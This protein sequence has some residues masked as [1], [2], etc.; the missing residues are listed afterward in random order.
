MHDT[1]HH[2]VIVKFI[3]SLLF[4]TNKEI[5]LTKWLEHGTQQL[6]SVCVQQMGR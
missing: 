1:A 2:L 4:L 6:R 3:Q 5:R